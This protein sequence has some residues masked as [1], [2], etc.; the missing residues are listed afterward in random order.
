MALLPQTIQTSE[1]YSD[2]APHPT[3]GDEH[4]PQDPFYQGQKGRLYE[5]PQNP[6]QWK[7]QSSNAVTRRRPSPNGRASS[8]THS[9]PVISSRFSDFRQGSVAQ[10]EEPWTGSGE[11]QPSCPDHDR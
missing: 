9:L 2:P 7:Q 1:I 10:W 8:P 4:S 11:E 3:E 5:E 6:D